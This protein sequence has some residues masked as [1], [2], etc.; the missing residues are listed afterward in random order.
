MRFE[1]CDAQRITRN[2][3]IVCFYYMLLFDDGKND[4]D[5]ILELIVRG[6]ELGVRSLG[7]GVRRHGQTIY[8][9]P[10]TPHPTQYAKMR[11]Y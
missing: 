1:L 9:K 10:R 7:Q 3:I 5:K 11:A 4:L 8:S 2:S 6:L